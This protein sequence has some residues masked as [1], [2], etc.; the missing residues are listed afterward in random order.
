MTIKEFNSLKEDSKRFTESLARKARD[1]F[2]TDLG[3]AMFGNIVE[4]QGEGEYRI[5]TRYC[6]STFAGMENQEYSLGGELW[7]VR[8]RAAIIALDMLRKFLLKQT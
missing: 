3:L 5:E 8:E 1:E 6:L 7:M 2:K 4:R